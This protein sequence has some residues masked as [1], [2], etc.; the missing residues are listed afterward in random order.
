MALLLPFAIFLV[1]VLTKVELTVLWFAVTG[2]G[3]LF[4]SGNNS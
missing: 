2:L 4:H 1:T 3:L